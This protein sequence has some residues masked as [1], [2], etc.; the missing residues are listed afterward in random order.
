MLWKDNKQHGFRQHHTLVVVSVTC[1]MTYFYNI[2]NMLYSLCEAKQDASV[3]AER[4]W[5]NAQLQRPLTS[6]TISRRA[7]LTLLIFSDGINLAHTILALDCVQS[8]ILYFTMDVD[9]C[10]M[11][12]GPDDVLG[13]AAVVAGIGQPNPL[14][15]QT[16]VPPHCYILV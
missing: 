4:L 5:M 11:V 2:Y 1:F 6:L 9:S 8:I 3:F 10:G 14:D 12:G 13:Q 7:V 16:A 15:V